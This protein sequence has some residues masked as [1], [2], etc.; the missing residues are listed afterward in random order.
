MSVKEKRTG[1]AAA[2]FRF[3]VCVTVCFLFVS[4]FGCRVRAA[5]VHVF[6]EASLLSDE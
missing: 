1:Y 4:V 5:S 6:D 2:A 3:A